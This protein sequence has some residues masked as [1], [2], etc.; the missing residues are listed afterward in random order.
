M[1]YY[2]V[3]P[4][5][6]EGQWTEKG[7]KNRT[8]DTSDSE[9]FVGSDQRPPPLFKYL[10]LGYRHFP[11]LDQIWSFHYHPILVP[12]KVKYYR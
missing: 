11:S 10:R 3:N 9:M 7:N 12:L 2:I 6:V 4:Y 8:I 5:G 1:C